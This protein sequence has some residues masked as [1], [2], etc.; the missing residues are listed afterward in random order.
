MRIFSL[1][2]VG[3]L[4]VSTVGCKNSSPAPVELPT[5]SVTVCRPIQRELA[6]YR[7]FSG[8]A[9]AVESVDVRARVKGF[10][11]KIHFREGTYVNKGQLLYEIDPRTF[12]AELDRSLAEVARLEALVKLTG[13]EAERAQRLRTSGALSEEELLQ[14]LTARQGAQ[15]SLQQAQAAAESAR[16]ELSFTRITA[17]IGGRISRTTVTEGNLVGHHEPTLLTTIVKLEPIY[18]YFEG[19]DRDLRDYQEMLRTGGATDDVYQVPVRVGT[20]VDEGHLL[21]GVIDFCDNR[22]DA[23]SGTILL[24]AVLPNSDRTLTPGQFVRVRVPVTPARLQ[25]L[26]PERALGA[27]QRGRY[28]LVVNASGT[29]EQRRVTV[30]AAQEGL[31]IVRTGLGLADRV[32][33]NGLQRARPGIQVAP[34]EEAATGQPVENR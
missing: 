29:V 4:V 5:P 27:D 23:G 12:Q 14:R 13:A 15:A 17:P 25:L 11:S 28:V 7:D 31:V 30:G 34:L 33:C 2:G 20:A 8:R 3:L 22:L 6:E 10:L 9:D 32:V 16:L 18:V 21:Q 19:S 26:I 1:A 24:R